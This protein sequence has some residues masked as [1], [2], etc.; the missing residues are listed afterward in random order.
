MIHTKKNIPLFSANKN[1]IYFSK[2]LREKNTQKVSLPAT[3]A[4]SCRHREGKE[5]EAASASPAASE[6]P[7]A[8]PPVAEQTLAWKL[9]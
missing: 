9:V 5:S 8:L 7:R 6:Q 1:L 3:Q 2:E 4:H